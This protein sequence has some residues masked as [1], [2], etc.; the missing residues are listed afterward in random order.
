M[1]SLAGVFRGLGI[2]DSK[3]VGAQNGIT[4][5]PCALFTISLNTLASSGILTLLPLTLDRAVAIIFPLKHMAFLDKNTSVLMIV[6][7]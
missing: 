2:I 5:L 6:L 7:T 3:H 4:S 1:V